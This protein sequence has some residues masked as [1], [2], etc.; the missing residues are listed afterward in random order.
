MANYNVTIGARFRP[1]TY[2]EMVKPIQAITEQHYA[3]EDAYYQMQEKASLYDILAGQAEDSRSRRMYNEF[4]ESLKQ[5]ADAL[6]KFGYN[7]STRNAFNQTRGLYAKNIIPLEEAKKQRD[8][9]ITAER[10]ALANGH[11]VLTKYAT[12]S[13]LDDFLDGKF[14]AKS[15]DLNTLYT[16]GQQL[17]AS[18]SARTTSTAEGKMFGGDYLKLVQTVG[19]PKDGTQEAINEAR[20]AV[21][22]GVKE[23]LAS[24]K[25]PGLS[26]G[27]AAAINASG[28][29]EL[30]DNDYDRAADSL[31][32]GFISGLTY[33]EDI[34]PM[35]NWRRKEDYKFAHQKALQDRAAALNGNNLPE[36]NHLPLNTLDL[37]AGKL[38][39]NQM[40][41]KGR[42]LQTIS[43]VS[44]TPGKWGKTAKI[45]LTSTPTVGSRMVA[46]DNF[47]I[48]W[49]D[50]KGNIKPQ[51]Q[52]LQEFA[53][54][55]GQK[56]YRLFKDNL[57]S[58]YYRLANEGKT[59]RE[60]SKAVNSYYDGSHKSNLMST[61]ELPIDDREN[62]LKTMVSKMS[63]H[64][65]KTAIQKVKR[66]EKDGTIVTDK[67]EYS[68]NDFFDEKSGNYKFGNKVPI[69]S[70]S[71]RKGAKEVFVQIGE[72]IY[73]FP[74]EKFGSLGKEIHSK[75]SYLDEVNKEWNSQIN[76]LQMQYPEVPKE[77]IE[78]YLISTPEGNKLKRSLDN[79]IDA[80]QR[81]GFIAIG[82]EARKPKGDVMTSSENRN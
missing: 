15:V 25:Y 28:A 1:F 10:Q 71:P 44:L 47:E 3:A 14:N 82:Y 78:R 11:T 55:Y 73:M 24:G 66:F 42:S 31:V 45:T 6:Y 49:F 41:N 70:V 27:I 51:S 53:R 43:G 17:G 74:T 40:A 26:E 12:Q 60:I 68:I 32:G 48:S 54:K 76:M 52:V 20:S 21:A 61:I 29:D 72:D 36:G 30:S 22:R 79:N 35:E 19:I 38:D 8:A 58:T 81:A 63:T 50:N 39:K 7:A 69:I 77:D 18:L 5:N 67:K 59:A 23:L 2:D 46:K 65:D 16:K 37:Q 13:N 64:G 4:S 62:V 57:K 34:K 33:K 80:F 56:N 9:A 75:A